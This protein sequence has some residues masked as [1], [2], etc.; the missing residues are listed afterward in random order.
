MLPLDPGGS[1]LLLV[2]H[3]DMMSVETVGGHITSHS[4]SFPKRRGDD[5]SKILVVYEYL[6]LY[7]LR[8]VVCLHEHCTLLYTEFM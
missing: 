3:V 5:M 2:A 7:A 8:P 4:L 1:Y 6:G